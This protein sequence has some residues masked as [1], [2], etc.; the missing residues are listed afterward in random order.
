MRIDWPLV[1]VAGGIGLVLFL[2]P[3]VFTVGLYA[4]ATP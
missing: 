3:L 2:V 1:L 4:A